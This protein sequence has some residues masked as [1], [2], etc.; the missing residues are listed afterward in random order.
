MTVK[1]ALLVL[2]GLAT[3]A[4]LLAPRSCTV[5]ELACIGDQFAQCDASGS[6]VTT[7]CAAGT[8]CYE[9]PVNGGTF[10]T[11]D[12]AE[13]AALRGAGA[14]G[15]TSA[16]P[17]SSSTPATDVRSLSAQ[18]GVLSRQSTDTPDAGLAA[19]ALNKQYQTLSPDAPCSTGQLACVNGQFAQCNFGTYALTQCAEGTIV[20][21][22]DARSRC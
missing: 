11:C 12:T 6:F 17:P 20:R 21:V 5:G 4:P 13:D 10:V 9:L 1:I 7:Q 15:A 14:P 18:R 8:S 3:A 19:Q 2:A 16:A 22:C